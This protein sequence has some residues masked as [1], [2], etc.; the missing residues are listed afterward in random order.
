[1]ASRPMRNIESYPSKQM[2][3]Y[4]SLVKRKIAEFYHNTWLKWLVFIA[5]PGQLM[6]SLMGTHAEVDAVL[7]ITFSYSLS[8]PW[9]SLFQGWSLKKMQKV[10]SLQAAKNVQT[11]RSAACF[12]S[13]KFSSD[14]SFSLI[15]RAKTSTNQQADIQVS[16]GPYAFLRDH[17]WKSDSCSLES[18]HKKVLTSSVLTLACVPIDIEAFWIISGWLLS[19]NQISHIFPS[20][21]GSPNQSLFLRYEIEKGLRVV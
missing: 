3:L 9:E 2:Y 15:G 12:K 5:F 18:E 10:L 13:L 4:L 17:P 6:V 16:L 11:N 19:E 20:P 1:M 14:V 21:G 8:R 7:V